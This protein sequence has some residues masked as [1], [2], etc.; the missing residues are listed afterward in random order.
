MEDLIKL[1][2]KKYKFYNSIL[3]QPDID[4][5][6]NIQKFYMVLIRFKFLSPFIKQLVK[7]KPNPTFN[8]VYAVSMT[9]NFMRYKKINLLNLIKKVIANKKSAGI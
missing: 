1:S 7:L 2:E 8:S 3:Q 5:V 6:M 9:L 4:T